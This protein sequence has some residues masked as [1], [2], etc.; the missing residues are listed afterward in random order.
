MEHQIRSETFSSLESPNGFSETREEG[1]IALGG[2]PFN[3]E[4]TA[5]NSDAKPSADN[6]KAIEDPPR[7]TPP[8]PSQKR[9][10]KGEPIIDLDMDEMT[11]EMLC[12][13]GVSPI[14]GV[15][16][17]L[18]REA[19]KE[20]SLSNNQLMTHP[21]PPK[22]FFSVEEVE[23]KRQKSMA[24]E[25]DE[26]HS[27]PLRPLDADVMVSVNDHVQ[28]CNLVAVLPRHF[29]VE[30]IM[31]QVIPTVT[32]APHTD[33]SQGRLE[34][35]DAGPCMRPVDTGSCE[36][37]QEKACVEPPHKTIHTP[38][39]PKLLP[40]L[41]RAQRAHL[42]QHLCATSSRPPPSSEAARSPLVWKNEKSPVLR[43]EARFNY[44]MYAQENPER[45]GP[46]HSF[47]SSC[48]SSDH[49]ESVP[50]ARKVLRLFSCVNGDMSS[51]EKKK[52]KALATRTAKSI[53][54]HHASI[55]QEI[56]EEWSG[57]PRAM[58]E[59][60]S[61]SQP[62]FSMKT[63]GCSRSNAGV[64]T[65]EEGS[66]EAHLGTLPKEEEEKRS[67]LCRDWLQEALALVV[68]RLLEVYER[69]EKAVAH[70]VGFAEAPFLS[71]PSPPPPSLALVEW[72]N[73]EVEMT[74]DTE[75]LGEEQQI[76]FERTYYLPPVPL[77]GAT[78]SEASSTLPLPPRG[79]EDAVLQQV[80]RYQVFES[81]L[82]SYLHQQPCSVLNPSPSSPSAEALSRPVSSTCRCYCCGRWS[83]S[84]AQWQSQPVTPDDPLL[85]YVD[86]LCASAATLPVSKHYAN[87]RAIRWMGKRATPQRG[88]Q[89]TENCGSIVDVSLFFPRVAA[90]EAQLRA[91][92]EGGNPK[93]REC[94]AQLQLLLA[95]LFGRKEE[96]GS[97]AVCLPTATEGFLLNQKKESS[98][99][100]STP[101]PQETVAKEAIDNQTAVEARI[102]W[103]R[104]FLHNDMLDELLLVSLERQGP[105]FPYQTIL[106]PPSEALMRL[107]SDHL[108]EVVLLYKNFV[109]VESPH[110]GVFSSVHFRSFVD[111][112]FHVVELYFTRHHG[113]LRPRQRS[114]LSEMYQRL[115]L[116][117]CSSSRV[118][119]GQSCRTTVS[120]PWQKGSIA[121]Q[122][123]GASPPSENDLPKVPVDAF[124]LFY[125]VA[126]F[127]CLGSFQRV[128]REMTSLFLTA[129]THILH[130]RTFIL[131]NLIRNAFSPSSFSSGNGGT[132]A[133]SASSSAENSSSGSSIGLVTEQEQLRYYEWY[134]TN[135][136]PG[137]VLQVLWESTVWRGAMK[138]AFQRWLHTDA[139]RSA[140][141][142]EDGEPA[143]R[144]TFCTDKA[145]ASE[146]MSSDSNSPSAK[147][148]TSQ[149]PLEED[150][151]E[152]DKASVHSPH[153]QWT[154]YGGDEEETQKEAPPPLSM[155]LGKRVGQSYVLSTLPPLITEFSLLSPQF[156]PRVGHW[157]GMLDSP[158]A[159]Q[160]SGSPSSRSHHTTLSSSPSESRD[161]KRSPPGDETVEIDSSFGSSPIPYY[162]QF[163]CETV[164]LFVVS[165]PSS[166]Q[167]GG[168]TLVQVSRQAISTLVEMLQKTGRTM[169]WG[170]MN[171]FINFLMESK[172]SGGAG[173]S[174][175][176][177]KR[178]V[179]TEE[180]TAKVS[181][182][183]SRKKK[184]KE[185][186]V[187]KK[188]KRESR[189]KTTKGKPGRK[190]KNQLAVKVTAEKS[191]VTVDSPKRGPGRPRK[192][193]LPQ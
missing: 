79:L 46:G 107:M 104:R 96:V 40:L 184:G 2:E 69:D 84:F 70:C 65:C 81:E 25:S 99:S 142:D 18:P 29:P 94:E 41:R 153:G 77:P 110:S 102:Q 123:E 168:N 39:T 115:P 85:P 124:P 135:P 136:S 43:F 17:D 62:S 146:E 163:S 134:A 73:G 37:P 95:S 139:P 55:K 189:K 177:K 54:E 63:A 24:L 71:D 4:T 190:P 166:V 178:S 187:P 159:S 52:K 191:E 121:L 64:S 145:S 128:T 11:Y 42:F 117:G 101:I 188:A 111:V 44:L 162:Q 9:N 27:Q 8:L 160:E 116:G 180:S 140:A 80:N 152:E 48:S 165:S 57:A 132:G 130:Q 26:T 100:A 15:G 60:V 89:E 22:H 143:Q 103:E 1:V 133:A 182:T 23:R 14:V 56:E 171:G 176:K 49:S 68:R 72:V 118:Y 113:G 170:E 58:W 174:H 105:H 6:K 87:T 83:A 125:H 10:R 141:L 169:N 12:T 114:I 173:P 88:S 7:R 179:H 66:R 151:V 30:H 82:Q 119:P 16:M 93:E 98:P 150:S 92:G 193:P 156:F 149:S 131:Y 53:L 47:S 161:V 38:R 147:P 19:E 175:P 186:E 106:C 3:R 21:P 75:G 155:L 67:A 127:H 109:F 185:R 181:F 34:E 28:L 90:R 51:R 172:R 183:P 74:V 164:P 129:A 76:R 86:Q 36:S 154:G 35:E 31:Q 5:T 45:G 122:S 192:H 13:T 148:E 138:E 137:G 167:L 157:L 20:E 108:E 158:K 50:N 112:L 61:S 33:H 91:A 97:T 32:Y 126:M 144:H 78:S 59:K 120:M